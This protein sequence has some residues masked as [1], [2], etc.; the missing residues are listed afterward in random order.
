MHKEKEMADFR[1][2]FIVLAVVTLF[3]SVAS[4]ATSSGVN[5]TTSGSVPLI[6]RGEGTSELVGDVVLSCTGG[7]GS[8]FP[9]NF[10]LTFGATQVT[11]RLLSSATANFGGAASGSATEALLVVDE[12][13][14]ANAVVATLAEATHTANGVYRGIL[15]AG[16]YGLQWNGIPFL[17]PGTD[18]RVLRFTNIRVNA[19]ALGAASSYIPVPITVNISVS[20]TSTVTLSQTSLT[21]GSAQKSYVFTVGSGAT[22]LQCVSHTAGTPD[23]TVTFTEQFA[24]A[25]KPKIGLT[26][27]DA[28]VNQDGSALVPSTSFNSESGYVNTTSLGSETGIASNGTR[29]L[30]TFTSIQSGVTI[31]VS[32]TQTT[33]G[34]TG[35]FEALYVTGA[36]AD[37]SGGSTVT[38]TSSYATLS[39]SGGNVWA[40][41]ETVRS[42]Q[43]VNEAATFG[44]GYAF[45]ANTTAGLP[46]L[47]SSGVT[48]NLAPAYASPTGTT[49]LT[50]AATGGAIPR[51]VL[52]PTAGSSFTIN[53]CVTDLLFP[54][55]ASDKTYDTGIVIANT[56]K[57]PFGTGQQTGACKFWFY[58]SGPSGEAAPSM[59]TS[60]S[61]APGSILAFSL[62]NGGSGLSGAGYFYGYM[63]AQCA[64][65][66]AH[67]YANISDPGLKVWAS[68]YQALVLDSGSALGR[69]VGSTYG[70][71]S[72]TPAERLLN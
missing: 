42:N 27:K 36:A 62:Q 25:F 45:T 70:Q 47:G 15:A 41:W 66:Y 65:Q 61:V 58:G 49:A 53:A 52:N 30:V 8:A 31:K 68:G 54:F 28:T 51:F 4:A 37:G 43:S 44:I 71:P 69:T 3:A 6:V 23:F 11:S 35:L 22:A 2:W 12:T 24:S 67:G 13:T 17:P 40:V 20:G 7:S 64:F 59:M 57:D 19:S 46:T 33:T 55:V 50:A 38:D 14:P 1:K 60:N 32:P 21:V 16:G 29:F 56:S 10:Q 9:I 34:G 5:C 26:T 48:G 18:T 72:S 63:I 39:A